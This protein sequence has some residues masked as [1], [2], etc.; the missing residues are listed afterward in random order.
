MLSLVGSRYD[1]SEYFELLGFEFIVLL[2]LILITDLHKALEEANDSLIRGK[3]GSIS[4]LLLKQ[5]TKESLADSSGLSSNNIKFVEDSF[6]E[7]LLVGLQLI[8]EVDSVV[9]LE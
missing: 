2:N 9:L 3:A 8:V 4:F 6:L 1:A 5:T 7:D